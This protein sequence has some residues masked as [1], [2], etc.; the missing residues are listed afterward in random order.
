[1]V[2]SDP[3][4]LIILPL[5][6]GKGKCVCVCVCV[7][8][9]WD[10]TVTNEEKAVDSEDRGKPCRQQGDLWLRPAIGR[11]LGVGRPAPRCLLSTLQSLG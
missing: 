7:R 2:D 5:R 4:L 8:S 1:M 9:C 6:A 11:E 3:T 10:L